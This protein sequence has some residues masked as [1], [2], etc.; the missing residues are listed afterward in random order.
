MKNDRYEQ[1]RDRGCPCAIESC[2]HHVDD[3]EAQCCY[4]EDGAGDP[5]VANCKKYVPDPFI[6]KA[7]AV[8]EEVERVY[9]SK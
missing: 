3:Q 4:G 5:T 1:W 7:W 8:Q 2:K 9:K 6:V